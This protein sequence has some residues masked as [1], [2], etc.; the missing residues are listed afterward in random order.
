M[1]LVEVLR[2]LDGRRR[3]L[4]HCLI[5]DVHAAAG[6]RPLSDQLWL[7]LTGSP[8]EGFVAAL[9]WEDDTLTGYGQ[10]A[11]GHD[12]STLEI[13]VD[14]EHEPTGAR[15][16][17]DAA[18]RAVAE[19][20]GGD[21]HWWMFDP[22]PAL[23]AVALAAGLEDRRALFQMRTALPL[24]D[25]VA[26]GARGVATRPFRIGEDEHAWLEVNNAAF[27]GHPEQG[28]W[29]LATLCRREEQPWFDPK[30]FLLHERDGRLAAFC[31]TKLHEDESPV[32]GEIYVIAVHPA[33]HGLGLGKAL[34]VAGLDHIAQRGITTGMLYVDRDNAAAVSLYRRLGFT[35][36]RTDRAFVATV[37]AVAPPH[38]T[39][40]DT[41]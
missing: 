29:D 13:V 33:F 15:P 11:R 21:V 3:D 10:L 17:L 37:P 26:G 40:G 16:L 36:H 4:V 9:A 19:S 7:D 28:G 35:T 39:S 25:D 38:L 6:R 14:A 32:L 22:S 34:T 5:A 1:P 23:E 18:L 8:R 41:A 30:G 12:G 27:A 20:G 2:I 24:P 31:W